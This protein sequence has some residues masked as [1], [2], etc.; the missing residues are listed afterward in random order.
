MQGRRKLW[1][2]GGMGGQLVI[3]DLLKE[4]VLLFFLPKS[5]GAIVPRT[6]VIPMVLLCCDVGGS[7]NPGGQVVIWWAYTKFSTTYLA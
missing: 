2:S 3:Q 4:R 7:E 1:K 6:P 5:G